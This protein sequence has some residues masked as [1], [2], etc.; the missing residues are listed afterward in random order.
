M[1]PVAVMLAVSLQAAPDGRSSVT[2]VVDGPA[3]G[4][5]RQTLSSVTLPVELRLA[6]TPTALE[7][8][9]QS[10]WPAKLAAA[11]KAYVG[12]QFAECLKQLEGDSAVPE[13][14]STGERALAARLLAWRAACHTG[15][16][17]P[18]PA[19]VA[20]E[21]LA[22]FQ[23]AVPEDVGSM[24]PDVEALLARAVTQVG[25]T[26]LRKLRVESTPSGASV[27]V[28]GRPAAC[29][30]PCTVDVLAGTHVLKLSAD[31]YSPSWQLVARDDTTAATLQAA[32]PEL[33][34]SQ[35]RARVQRGDAVDSD[36]SVKL[37]SNALRAPRLAVVTSDAAAPKTLRGALAVDGVLTTRAERLGDA[38][39]L[40]RDLLVRG[41]IVEETPPFYKR[42]P[43]WVAVGVA[44][45]AAGVTTAVL[46]STRR[47]IT[48][49]ELKP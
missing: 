16:N 41:L 9:T 23:L 4:E 43:F 5:T 6:D 25:A 39:G 32:T 26:P 31:G 33:A 29:T 37:L 13:L 44:A 40:V 20:A 35:W 18:Q 17:Q 45:V 24:T 36:A 27:E 34:A 42:W 46:V 7:A 28:D 1:F 19:R 11:R 2:V 15:A 48:S 3:A 49:V 12:A 10:A 38:E 30:T 47:T 8:P 14:L 22:T 21:A